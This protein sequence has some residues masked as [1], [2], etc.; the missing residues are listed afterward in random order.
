MSKIPDKIYYHLGYN[1][2]AIV[3]DQERKHWLMKTD[4]QKTIINDTGDMYRG[5]VDN[6]GSDIIIES[7]KLEE[8]DNTLSSLIY[9]TDAT[10]HVLKTDVSAFT[11]SNQVNG[12]M[13]ARVLS[14]NY[15]TSDSITNPVHKTF[16][17]KLMNCEE[18]IIPFGGSFENDAVFAGRWIVTSTIP[19]LLLI[20]NNGQYTIPV[21]LIMENCTNGKYYFPLNDT[22][23][24][25]T[26]HNEGNG[27][28]TTD[29]LTDNSYIGYP[30]YWF[31]CDETNVGPTI[32]MDNNRSI[33]NRQL[34]AIGNPGNKTKYD[35]NLYVGMDGNNDATPTDDPTSTYEILCSPKHVEFDGT[36]ADFNKPLL[37]SSIRFKHTS[38][39]TEYTFGLHTIS[40]DNSTIVTMTYNENWTMIDNNTYSIPM[41]VFDIN[42]INNGTNALLPIFDVKLNNNIP[43]ATI[44]KNDVGYAGI[45]MSSNCTTSDVYPRYP[46]D[47]NEW[48]G[49]PEWLNDIPENGVPQHLAIYAIHNTPGYVT[50]IPDSRQT[51]ALLLDPGKKKTD[52]SET[53]SNDERG[54]VYL[55]SNDDTQY[56]NNLMEKLKE[57]GIVKPDRTI[58]RVCDIPT[59]IFDLFD[60]S[61]LSDTMVVDKKYIR[62]KASY[63]EDDKNRLWNDLNW[64]DRW[65]RPTAYDPVG[66][67]ITIYPD[68]NGDR[69]VFQNEDLL[70]HVDMYDNNDFRYIENLN[71]SI[72]SSHVHL[73]S[74][75]SAGEGYHIGDTGVIIVGGFAFVYEVLDINGIGGV[76]ELGIASASESG[77][78]NIANFDMLPGN[79]G[80][81]D[82]YGTSP[83]DPSTSGTGLTIQFLLE[84]Y[85][86]LLPRK[87][88]PLDMLH[89]LV[90]DVDGV[91]LYEYLY[92]DEDVRYEWKKS[93]MVSPFGSSYPIINKGLTSSDTYLT[94]ILPNYTK[95][96]VVNRTKN[97]SKENIEACVTNSFIN[98][99]DK[100]K[101]PL[102]PNQSSGEGDLS[103]YTKVNLCKFRCD[104][105]HSAIA[106]SHTP[107]GVMKRLKELGV[108]QYDCYVI[109]KWNEPTVSSNMNFQYGIITR[110]LN[111]YVST[112]TTTKLPSNSLR[113]NK[114]VHTNN[115]TTVVWDAP[116]VTG[117][118][119]WVYDPSSTT[120]EDYVI[121]VET[122]ELYVD[123][124]YVRWNDVDVFGNPDLHIVNEETQRFEWAVFTNNPASIPGYTPSASDP[125]YQQPEFVSLAVVGDYETES[126]LPKG[127]WKLVFPRCESFTMKNMSNGVT[128]KPCKLQMLRVEDV[129]SLD[130]IY[131]ENGNIVNQKALVLHETS[132]GASLNV[133]NSST[134][135]WD[136]V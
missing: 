84:D 123:R 67:P 134:G 120:V 118:M 132:T 103:K 46:Y 129:S 91:Y 35:A 76:T 13:F 122:Q 124:R 93:T 29:A 115:S 78:I 136:K 27:T 53:L 127:N 58:A 73:A 44:D 119:M 26:I 21:D 70:N 125:L 108:L 10:N 36:D 109:W 133:F 48:D 42:C 89:A 107:E 41:N 97:K 55:L 121:N 43:F 63:S 131:D 79:S 56:R 81:T 105:I 102:T 16:K 95:L 2:L 7:E 135:Q 20:D 54:R 45:R 90:R 80:L 39:D 87:S 65:V 1:N 19:Q 64:Y 130:D 59:S 3:L 117:V 14:I 75:I 72:P 47:L 71:A 38:D 12:F 49:L 77:N 69:Y 83:L 18:C 98:I 33:L 113:Y 50:S 60:V 66:N 68:Q 15:P 110:S 40:G 51:A 22:L 82:T 61:G 106:Y 9:E 92:N 8:V 114:Y 86:S 94:S 85:E 57:D 99:I 128:L 28:Y 112:D 4:K 62:S 100:Q 5:T 74:I 34:C 32:M 30:L 37:L 126:R 25:V 96:S 17:L 111:N 52:D 88:D 116:G 31:T 23:Q 11:Y 24:P 101:T 6:I 104:G